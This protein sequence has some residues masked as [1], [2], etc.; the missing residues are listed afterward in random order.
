VESVSQTTI[1][2]LCKTKACLSMYPSQQRRCRQRL[3]CDG[4][5]PPLPAHA[6]TADAPTVIGSQGAPTQPTSHQT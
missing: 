5:E 4:R 2:L 3:Y 6:P 1:H